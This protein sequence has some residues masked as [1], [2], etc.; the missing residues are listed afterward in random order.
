MIT[1]QQATASIGAV[2]GIVGYFLWSLLAT[3]NFL[4]YS[5]NG[6]PQ[7]GN[8]F[9]VIS[10]VSLLVA[11]IFAIVAS[12]FRS[13]V[14]WVKKESREESG[15]W[16]WTTFFTVTVAAILLLV[17]HVFTL[18]SYWVT[19]L[20][21]CLIWGIVEYGKYKARNRYKKYLEASSGAREK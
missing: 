1:Q 11:A 19:L 2:G 3:G 7:I 17:L 20:S 13:I 10:L 14:S 4:P 8:I 5:Q 12:L 18:V 15:T 9:I 16:V 6:V 21:Y